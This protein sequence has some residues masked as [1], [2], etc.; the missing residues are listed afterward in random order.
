[1][2]SPRTRIGNKPSPAASQ[3]TGPASVGTR[4][5]HVPK[6]ADQ[7]EGKMCHESTFQ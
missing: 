5:E 2:T 1:M 6:V 7:T 3:L 4:V